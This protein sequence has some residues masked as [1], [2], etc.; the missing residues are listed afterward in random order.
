MSAPA[1]PVVI[2]PGLVKTA[3]ST[4]QKHVFRRHPGI[5][6][7]GLPAPTPELEWALRH[8][9]QANSIDYE[10]ERLKAVLDAAL[11]P[12]DPPRTPLLSYEN[13][14]LHES[15]DK[16]LVAQRLQA[17]FPDAR[18]VF[19]I[20][21]QEDLVVSW[22][23]TKLRT[24]IKRK[25]YV[26]FEEWYWV[27]E[28]EP[29]RT[30]IDDLRYGRMIRYYASL[31]GRDRVRVL[32]FEQLRRDSQGYARAF[33]EILGVDADTF[34]RLMSGKRENAAMSHRYLA[35]WRRFGHLLPRKLV[36]EW[37]RSDTLRRGAPARIEVP[38][39][40]RLHIRELCADDNAELARAFDLDL[41]GNGY[42][43][44]DAP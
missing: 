22:Y 36:R 27:G 4:L 9:C 3:T 38:E 10:P 40:V 31:F 35:F 24:L 30:I 25:A 37:A 6:F 23:L 13:F 12:S 5:Q 20:R 43:L 2:H 18:I 41:A 42:A 19:T 33:A 44:P 32:L 1:H 29:H 28:R 15:K 34:H 39:K 17:L 26:P 11:T 21:R 8:I 7:L 14:A 16:G